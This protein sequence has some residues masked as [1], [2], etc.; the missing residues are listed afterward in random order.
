MKTWLRELLDVLL[1]RGATL[2][3]ITERPDA[4]LRGLI[5][6]LAVALL[7][8]LPTLVTDVITGFR[9]PAVVEPGDM[10][11]GLGW[12]ADVMRPWLRSAGVPDAAIDQVIQV[13]EG[14]AGMALGIA[15]QVQQLPTALPRPLAQGFI[16]LGRWL[17]GPFA[18][19]PL[20]LVAAT[21]STWLGYG[22]LVMLAAKLLGGRGTLHGFFG[23]TAFFAVPHILD[24]FARV[25]VAGPV[26]G[27]IAFLWGLV[28][29]VVATAVSHR[30][31]ASRAL[32]AVFAPFVL[33]LVLVSLVLL[34]L[35]I[36]GITAGLGGM[37]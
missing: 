17:S 24:I 10:S 27:V 22:V 3:R 5:V 21:L 36:F 35:M 9:P 34:V 15:A 6:L 26:L 28:I 30:L 20:P 18:N 23:A 2:A 11:S 13:A 12:S 31:S 33:L 29:Y 25:P 1:L 37:Q 8:G 4:F 16:S 32:A 14:N 19:S 7:V